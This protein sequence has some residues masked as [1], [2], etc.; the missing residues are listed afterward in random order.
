MIV[1]KTTLV[2]LGTAFSAAFSEG[3][4]QA[5]PQHEPITMMTASMTSQNE[6]G[7]LGQ[8]SSMREWL[9]DRTIDGLTQH[10]YA[11][12]NRK[13]ESTVSVRR[14]DIEDDNLGVYT[15][16]F[17]ELGRAAAAHPCELVFKALKDGF[18]TKCYDGQY[19]FDSDHDVEGASYSNTGGGSGT[20]WYLVDASRM[21]KPI[22]FQRRRDYTLTSVM[23]LDDQSVFRRDEFL[24]GV[25]AR[26]NVGYG[27]WQ[28]AYGSKQALTVDNYKTART[29]ML[30]VKGDRGR[31]M[32]VMPTHLVV[33]PSLEHEGLKL[34]NAELLSDGESNVYR[35]TAQLIVSPWLA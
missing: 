22:I 21:I 29:Q 7:W 4:G 17:Q 34:L 5:P 32:G 23:D 15:P 8:M 30:S 13:F 20:A 26:V 12:K 9:G 16:L 3:F 19:F 14:D 6:Y 28:L 27:L 25:D 2:T 1:N 35:G 11:I 10:G 24:H 31:P 18:S 33:P